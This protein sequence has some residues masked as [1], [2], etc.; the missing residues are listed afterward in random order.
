MHFQVRNTSSQRL[1]YPES[2]SLTPC[3]ECFQMG[4]NLYRRQSKTKAARAKP[5]KICQNELNHLDRTIFCLPVTSGLMVEK[6]HIGGLP[7]SLVVFRLENLLAVGAGVVPDTMKG[8][9]M[10]GTKLVGR[11]VLPRPNGRRISGPSLGMTSQGRAF[12]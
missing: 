5:T 11:R 1:A 12:I 9:A 7:D 4:R 10:A 8:P 3:I 6:F 2:I